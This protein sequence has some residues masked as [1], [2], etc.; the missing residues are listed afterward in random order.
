MNQNRVS[1][2]LHEKLQRAAVG[3]R[4]RPV[5][6]KQT[7]AVYEM[8]QELAANHPTGKAKRPMS[9]SE[10]IERLII[11]SYVDWKQ[12]G[13]SIALID[14]DAMDEPFDPEAE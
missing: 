6:L 5:N 1:D 8:L 7:V 9:M 13:E 2:D 3:E 10:V 11:Q 4:T 12:D 14:Y